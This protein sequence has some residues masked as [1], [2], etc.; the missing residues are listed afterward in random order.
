MKKAILSFLLLVS[1]KAVCQNDILL[2]TT[3]QKAFGL[4]GYSDTKIDFRNFS[5][6]TSDGRVFTSENLKGKVTFIN[7][8]FEA[9]APCAAEFE[10]LNALYDKYKDNR[11][12]QFISFTFES[13]GDI[14]HIV[15][16]HHLKYP[17]VHLDREKI[18]ELIFQ[19]GFPTNIITDVSGKISFIKTGGLLDKKK[20]EAEFNRVYSGQI[21][22]LLL[23]Q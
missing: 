2:D 10:A 13:P 12:F 9:C 15:K 23:P 5:V 1:L 3:M 18:Y 20:V 6:A 21:E 22:R 19:L 4:N 7:F 17:V 11:N 14:D 16:K 8:W